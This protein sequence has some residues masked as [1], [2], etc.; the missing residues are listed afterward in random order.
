[1]QRKKLPI[2]KR[3]NC[4]GFAVVS[5]IP[6]NI[7]QKLSFTYQEL[8]YKNLDLLGTNDVKWIVNAWGEPKK[9]STLHKIHLYTWIKYEDELLKKTKKEMN[10]FMKNFN[11]I[12]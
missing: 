8:G 7:L 12:K 1:M 5:I 4:T 2:S 3:T 6:K 11:R 10:L 9:H